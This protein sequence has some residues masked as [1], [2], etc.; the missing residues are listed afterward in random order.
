MSLVQKPRTNPGSNHAANR[1]TSRES[2]EEA[3]VTDDAPRGVISIAQPEESSPEQIPGVQ[4]VA[5]A[6]G[7]GSNLKLGHTP[8]PTV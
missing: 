4:R 5:F 1:S 2:R 3:K 7:T 8:N 6:I